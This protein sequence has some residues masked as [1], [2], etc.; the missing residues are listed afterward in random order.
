[1]GSLPTPPKCAH[2]HCAALAFR[3]AWVRDL[4]Q[5]RLGPEMTRKAQ[6][7]GKA[8]SQLEVALQL[9]LKVAL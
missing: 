8:E 5:L 7:A 3:H 9:A 1:M 2:V 4:Y 6:V